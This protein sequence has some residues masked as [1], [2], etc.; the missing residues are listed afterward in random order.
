MKWIKSHRKASCAIAG[1]LL[2]WSGLAMLWSLPAM[3]I[4]TGTLM[5]LGTLMSY[6]PDDQPPSLNASHLSA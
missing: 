2:I 4:A 6:L 1:S 5:T 3:L